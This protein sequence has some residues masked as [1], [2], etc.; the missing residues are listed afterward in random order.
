MGGSL[1][2]AVIGVG[3]LGRFHA[4]KYAMIEDVELVGV[5]DQD[6]ARARQVSEETGA[7]FFTDY[8]SLLGKVDLV[9][10]CVPTQYHYRIAGACLEAGCHVLVEKPITV[11]VEEA[12]ELI[13]IAERE[14]CVLQVGHLKRFH[15]AVVALRES[16]AL[17][18]PLFIESQR[19]APFKSRAL[20]V[21]VVLD[22]MIHDVDLILNFVDSE[23][24]S[25]DAVGAPVV[26][27]Q[28]DMANARLKFANGCVANITASRIA[29]DSTR[30]IRLFQEDAFVSLDFISKDIL[31]MQ[32]GEGTMELDGVQI[33]AIEAETLKIND[34]D[35]LEVEI[36]AFCQAVR[37]ETPPLV[38]GKDGRRALEVV[39]TIR[40]SIKAFLTQVAPDAPISR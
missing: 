11:T 30:R 40:A 24:T 6:E 15:P 26:T 2:A 31:L 36:R 28:V 10:V 9:S 18:R 5:V 33:P 27:D 29:R 8:R 13:H 14:N 1:R 39:Q 19:L 32:R 38:S 12:D 7:P 16:G 4:H 17:K 23:L 3:Y 25:V 20:D 35:T 21:D 37:D 34:Y 22:L